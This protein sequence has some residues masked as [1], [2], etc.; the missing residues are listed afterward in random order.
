[1]ERGFGGQSLVVRLVEEVMLPRPSI[2]ADAPIAGGSPLNVVLGRALDESYVFLSGL[3]E[4]GDTIF[5]SLQMRAV[6]PELE[7]LLTE[8]RSDLERRTVQGVLDLAHRCANE[9]HMYLV[10]LGD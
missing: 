3:D 10:F 1:M 7:R 9:V 5:N 4:Y 8:T 2:P 6:I